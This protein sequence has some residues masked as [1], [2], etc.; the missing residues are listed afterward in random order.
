MSKFLGNY[1][2]FAEAAGGIIHHTAKPT[3]TAGVGRVLDYFLVE[4]GLSS[5]VV[6]LE[7]MEDTLTTPHWPIKLT[8]RRPLPEDHVLVRR[9]KS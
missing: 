8:L 6:S 7:R 5:L 2:S 1:F 9:K 4:H 3:C